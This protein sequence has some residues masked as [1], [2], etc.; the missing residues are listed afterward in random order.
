MQTDALATTRTSLK[1]DAGGLYA[2][3]TLRSVRRLG[4]NPAGMLREICALCVVALLGLSDAPSS[5]ADNSGNAPSVTPQAK[6]TQAVA[7]TRNRNIKILCSQTRVEKDGSSGFAGLGFDPWMA[8]FFKT[9]ESQLNAEGKS[10]GNTFKL[11]IE[12]EPGAASGPDFKFFYRM[13]D[14]KGTATL[15]MTDKDG[16]LIHEFNTTK[17]YGLD[18]KV[19]DI[20]ADL[21]HQAYLWIRNGGRQSGSK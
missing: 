8:Y 1:G 11:A 3:A 19:A 20:Y 5:A 2:G 13:D 15:R 12:P 4:V 17:S 18:S 6:T 16:A 21:N 9:C 10:D 14:A 7:P